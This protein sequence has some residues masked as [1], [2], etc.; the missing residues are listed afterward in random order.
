MAELRVKE[1]T[2]LY[3]LKNMPLKFTDGWNV[4]GERKR[5]VKDDSMILSW[6]T[7]RMEVPFTECK[8][9]S[10]RT[11]FRNVGMS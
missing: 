5:R 3:I 7:G 6:A 10:E 4:G 1:C 9:E 8:W 11:R 2:R